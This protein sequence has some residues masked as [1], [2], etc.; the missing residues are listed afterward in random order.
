L[1]CRDGTAYPEAWRKDR[2][3]ILLNCFEAV[4]ER[5][6]G[7]PIRILSAYRSPAHNAKVGGATHSQHVEGRALDLQP[8]AGVPLRAFWI[9]VK[10]LA[11]T[12][13]LRG[14]GFYAD[15]G[16]VHIDTRPSTVTHIWRGGRPEAEVA[17]AKPHAIK[18]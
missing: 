7:K 13:P 11:R 5:C 14:L 2:L 15:A 10:D 4:R 16:F 12:L 9:I 8:P 1:A 3:P 17:G 6:G 18:G